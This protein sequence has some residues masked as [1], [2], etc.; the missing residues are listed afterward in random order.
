MDDVFGKLWQYLVH[1]LLESANSLHILEIGS[2]TG[3]TTKKL[4]E[5]CLRK[6]G[7]LHAIDPSPHYDTTKW[8]ERYGKMFTFHQKTSLEALPDIS[9]YDTVLIDGD[10]NWYTIFNE[11]Q[12]IEKHCK[13][14]PLVLLNDTGW[15]Y[16]RRDLYYN[17]DTIPSEFRHTLPT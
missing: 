15:P 3:N 16:A 8:E 9:G 2:E 6:N 14:F 17:P 12:L 13:T 4:A 5:Y 1:P 7:T 10:H 11:L